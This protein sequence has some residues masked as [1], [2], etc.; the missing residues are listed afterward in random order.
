MKQIFFNIIFLFN[1]TFCYY[2]L[3][4]N[5]IY[6]PLINNNNNID[7]NEEYFKNL[8]EN[9]PINYSELNLINETYIET[10]NIN[11]EQY[12]VELYLGTNKQYF[13]LLLSTIDNYI[14]VSSINCKLCNVSNKYN[15]LL[16]KT[17]KKLNHP[18]NKRKFNQNMNYEFFQ[19]SFFIPS[20]SVINNTIQKININISTLNFKVIE[21]DSSGFLNSNLIDGILGLNYNNNSELSNYNIIK[22]LYNIGYI[23]S[24]SFSIIITSSN[25]NR[26]YLGDIM[27]NE[28]VK[29]YLKSSMKKGKCK[30]IE[31]NWKCKLN[32]LK[33]NSLKN[34]ES[35]KEWCHSTLSLNLK[36]DKL[37]IPKIY[38]YL[39]VVGYQYKKVKI[40]EH[41]YNK[42]RKYD[43][44]C[45]IY[46]GII[47]CTCANKNDFGI[48]T[49]Y[50]ENDSKLNI[51]L[52]NYVYYNKSVFFFKC[53][54][55]IILSK[56]D[57][58]IVGLRGLNNTILSFNMEEK[59]IKFFQKNKKE[60]NHWYLFFIAIILIIIGIMKKDK[61]LFIIGIIMVIFLTIECYSL[62]EII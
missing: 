22:E 4:L 40:T 14:T 24:P 60:I 31:N 21:F 41:Y 49:L 1:I 39:I 37:I 57:E 25:I 26:F 29:N 11:S 17:N 51:D 50:F 42:I 19:D 33:Y 8:K 62:V 43:K 30:I 44:F 27:K 16:S 15:P 53:K 7:D 32:R 9:L 58:F 59:T 56:N 54:I 5:K 36:E 12:I 46:D 35:T 28:Y 45:K 55:D 18:N 10:K 61:V 2:S 34:L 6:I 13:K 3:E 47:Y 20:E 48:V 38:Y 52:R 23:S